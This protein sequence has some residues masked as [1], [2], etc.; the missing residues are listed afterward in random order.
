TSSRRGAVSAA[1]RP[2][3]RRD[4]ELRAWRDGPTRCGLGSAARAQCAPDLRDRHGLRL[5]RPGSRWAR[6]RRGDPTARRPP[7]RHR[8]GGQPY[9]AGASVVDFWGG[10]HLYGG[11]VTALF[12]RTRTGRGRLVEVALQEALYPAL[13]SNLATHYY[14]GAAAVRS[15]NRNAVLAPYNLFP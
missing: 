4:R 10:T 11:I 2:R 9:K 8:W 1:R 13:T 15:G 5:D 6:A 12:A 3:G 14:Q 7:Q